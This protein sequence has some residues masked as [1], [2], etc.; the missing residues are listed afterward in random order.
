MLRPVYVRL[1]GFKVFV[2]VKRAHY[3]CKSFLNVL[4]VGLLWSPIKGIHVRELLADV[5]QRA[6][7]ND[8]HIMTFKILVLYCA[9]I[10]YLNTSGVFFLFY[11]FTF[12]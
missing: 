9:S 1:L 12:L 2:Q 3:G 11:L 10:L 6:G 4:S 5:K 7:D 8:H